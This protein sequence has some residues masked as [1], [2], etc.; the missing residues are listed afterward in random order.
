[1]D[2]IDTRRAAPALA[3]AALFILLLALVA[4]AP[5][6]AAPR[7]GIT[8]AR[9]LPAEA[10]ASRAAAAPAAG[11]FLTQPLSSTSIAA[12]AAQREDYAALPWGAA[13]AVGAVGA[14]LLLAAA[15]GYASRRR[16]YQ[17]APTELPSR[18]PPAEERRKAA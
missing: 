10:A 4:A 14:A 8:A 6:A 11:S 7:T 15:I 1:M 17:A 9:G 13:W 2:L 12:P 5:A 16:A 18:R 3:W